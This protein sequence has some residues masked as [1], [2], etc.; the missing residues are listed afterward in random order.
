VGCRIVVWSGIGICSWQV[1][2]GVNN[3]LLSLHRDGLG[4]STEERDGITIK[5]LIRS[6]KINFVHTGPLNFLHISGIES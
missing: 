3:G 1:H 6:T 4:F 2:G 5:T